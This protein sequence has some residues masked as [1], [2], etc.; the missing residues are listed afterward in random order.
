[1]CIL[2]SEQKQIEK[3]HNIFPV[4]SFRHCSGYLISYYCFRR[5]SFITNEFE[6]IFMFTNLIFS[7]V[8]VAIQVSS[9]SISCPSFCSFMCIYAIESSFGFMCFQYLFLQLEC[10]HLM[11]A[12]IN[13]HS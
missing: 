7:F 5:I 1:M 12:F 6:H 9:F 2:K 10:H 11:M 4:F 13:I 8:K 3:E